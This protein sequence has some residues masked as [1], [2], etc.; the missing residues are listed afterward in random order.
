[1]RGLYSLFVRFYG[2]AINLASI[3][4]EKARKWKA[5]RKNYFE[6]LPKNLKGCFWIHC[7]S[8]GEFEQGRP[9]IEAI[10]KRWNGKILLTFF[11]P[12]GFE[13]RKD[14]PLV[15]HVAYLPLDTRINGQKLIDQIKPKAMIFVK[16][17]VWHN[18]YREAF[19]K[20]I[21]VYLISAIFRENQYYF[22]P[23][24]KWF[25]DTLKKV[26]KIFCQDQ[27]TVSL[28]SKKGL[29]NAEL[30][31]DTRFDRVIEIAESGEEISEIKKWVNG[32]KAIVAGSTWPEDEKL[33]A[34]VLTDRQDWTLII[35]P[36]E[37]KQK[38]LNSIQAAFA[39][40]TLYSDL[41]GNITNS[42]VLIIDSIGLLSRI[43]RYGQIAY[44]GGGF[45]DGIHNT[46]EAA[47]YGVPVIF[48]PNYLKF[49]EAKDLIERGGAFPVKDYQELAQTF[50]RLFGEEKYREESGKMAGTY[51]KIQSGATKKIIGTIL[52]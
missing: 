22:K 30:S 18:L 23:F 25:L 44:I 41:N 36:H 48:G 35:A 13:V 28:L 14:F 10:R 20:D 16:Y 7:A 12:S 47:V 34:K 11:S 5:G 43:Y 50:T 27:Q 17:E 42:R 32:R 31:G 26:D 45:G 2:I 24:G 37:I 29:K 1:M 6:S 49:K 46:L 39:G 21:P 19:N 15:D 3:F 40:S 33:L 8:L 51:V 9:I 4:N 38:K 52:N